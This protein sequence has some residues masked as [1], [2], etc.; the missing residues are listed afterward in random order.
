MI[1][2]WTKCILRGMKGMFDPRLDEHLLWLMTAKQ[3]DKTD[4][5]NMYVNYSVNDKLRKS[6]KKK[7]R[8]G[9]CQKPTKDTN[10]KSKGCQKR[11]MSGVCTR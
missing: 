10:R 11:L 1:E 9:T 8:T 5:F 3:H 6:K 7:L 2:V 4:S